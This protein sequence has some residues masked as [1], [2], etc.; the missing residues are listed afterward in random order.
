MTANPSHNAKSSR[1]S[2]YFSVLFSRI[3]SAKVVDNNDQT[4]ADDAVK[5]NLSTPIF[6]NN[7]KTIA[8]DDAVDDADNAHVHTSPDS[9]SP[10]ENNNEQ[11][12]AD[13]DAVT[14][15]SSVELLLGTDSETGDIATPV[16]LSRAPQAEEVVD[17]QP[18]NI[19]EHS[20]YA[21]SVA[22]AAPVRFPV[23]RT[24]PKIYKHRCVCLT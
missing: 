12:V 1:C 17:K 11:T 15:K 21:D 4:V 6:N 7:V 20:E 10:T 23:R 3:M 13:D 19:I 22:A 24:I 18:A 5:E 9:S 8:T 2:Q 14:A 16:V